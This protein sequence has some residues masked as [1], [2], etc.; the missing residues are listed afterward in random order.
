ML[1]HCVELVSRYYGMLMHFVC[2]MIMTWKF[3]FHTSLITAYFC[4]WMASDG[5]IFLYA[6][7]KRLSNWKTL[8]KELKKKL[9]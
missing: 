9:N 5:L 7:R 3:Y 6:Y 2:L 8:R 4:N 1:S